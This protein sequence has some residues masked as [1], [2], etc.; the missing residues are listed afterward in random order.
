MPDTATMPAGIRPRPYTA[1]AYAAFRIDDPYPNGFVPEP[2]PFL[3]ADEPATLDEALAIVVPK[4]AHKSKLAIRETDADTGRTLVHLYTIRQRSTPEYYR[5]SR[6]I[7]QRSHR[8]YPELLAVIDGAV[9][10]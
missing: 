4:C 6:G 5:D 9:L 1:K 3:F 7:E 10:S 2:K 8:L